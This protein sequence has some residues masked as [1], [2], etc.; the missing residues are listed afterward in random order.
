MRSAHSRR[1][2]PTVASMIALVLAS[3]VWQPAEAAFIQYGSRATFDALGSFIA[4]DWGVFGSAGTV[5][6]TPDSR[7]V[8]GLA[9]GV[10]STQGALARHD[11]GTDFTGTFAPGDRLLTDAG[12]L[13]DSFVVTFGLP[14]IGFGTQIDIHSRLGAYTGEIELFSASSVLLF[15][16]PF[17]GNNTGLED[18]SAPFVGVTSDIANIA[19]AKF[20]IDQPGFFPDRSGDLGINRLD[21]RTAVAEPSTLVLVGSALLGIVGFGFRRRK[22]V[23]AWPDIIR[24]G[25]LRSAA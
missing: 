17:A 19:F 10:T 25:W 21:I 11:E 4:V 3:G 24:F 12:S 8:G 20:W 23:S 13:S 1:I 9:I 5:I 7:N 16:A 15:T 18:N 6:S 22:A 2:L 14:V